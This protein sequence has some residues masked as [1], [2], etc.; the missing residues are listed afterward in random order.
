[1]PVKDMK[2]LRDQLAK[3][4]GENRSLEAKLEEAYGKNAEQAL[5]VDRLALKLSLATAKLDEALA[6]IAKQEE[7]IVEVTESKAKAERILQYYDNAHTP[8]RNRTIT[9]REINKQKKEWKKKNPAGR[10]GR[11]KGCTNTAVSR[12]ATRTVVHR[13]D[14]CKSCGGGNLEA[15]RTDNELVVDIPFIPQIEVVNH[16]LDTCKCLDCGKITTSSRTGLVRGT[17]LGPKPAQDD[18]RPVE[19]ERQLRGYRRV[20]FGTLRHGR[21]RQ[22]DRPARAGQHDPPDGTGCQSHVRGDEI[23]EGPRRHR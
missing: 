8:S 16:R 9:Q 4:I 10:R 1:M 15:E 14:R 20:L 2:L 18:R 21:V 5:M 3:V 23:Q 12:K 17:S 7:I 6:K 13:P 19:H 11:H 22:V